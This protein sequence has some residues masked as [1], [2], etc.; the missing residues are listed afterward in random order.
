[1]NLVFSQCNQQN[2]KLI[3][4]CLSHIILNVKCFVSFMRSALSLHMEEV[5]ILKPRLT[6]NSSSS[7]TG[8]KKNLFPQIIETSVK[9]HN[10]ISRIMTMSKYDCTIISEISFCSLF[11]GESVI[12]EK[13]VDKMSFTWENTIIFILYIYCNSTKL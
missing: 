12:M 6:S 4:Q 10:L 1:M 7:C 8:K 11:Q 3:R 2:L 5:Q 9:C 13:L